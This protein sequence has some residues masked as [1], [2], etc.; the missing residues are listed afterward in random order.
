MINCH[1]LIRAG[2]IGDR[3]MIMAT[4][5]RKPIT[6]L[7]CLQTANISNFEGFAYSLFRGTMTIKHDCGK[8]KFI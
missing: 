8:I 4:C 6:A 3:T 2:I 5:S 7:M 1:R